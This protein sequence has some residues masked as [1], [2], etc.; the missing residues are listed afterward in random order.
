MVEENTV[1]MESVR[2]D[3]DRRKRLHLYAGFT[4]K[5]TNHAITSILVS[6]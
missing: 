5:H 6:V 3:F 2:T 1:N 4:E